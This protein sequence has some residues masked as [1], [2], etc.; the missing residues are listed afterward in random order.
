[1]GSD[2]PPGAV[3]QQ[4]R[5]DLEQWAVGFVDGEG[6][7][8]I[9][10]VRN[11]VCRLGWQ[12][13]HE[14]SVTQAAP[15]RPAL[16]LLIGVFGCG[17]IIGNNRHDDHRGQLLRF[18]VKR[19]SD[20]VSLVVPFFEE[21]PLRT[22]KRSD[23]ERFVQVLHLMQ[24]GAHLTEAGLHDIAAITQQMN[25]KQRSRYLESSEAIRQPP[26]SDNEVK[27]WSEPHGDMRGIS[28]EIPCRVSSDLHEW[29]NDLAT[30]S[31]RD[32]AKLHDE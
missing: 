19:R 16:E 8:S 21:R 25:R 18:S 14:F 6:C 28:S 32:P 3:N 15:S 11:R 27:R 17:T 4:E 29:R 30:V 26:R 7:F 2:N 24:G 12:V 22:A 13:Q 23:F 1:V 10:V 31:T 5:P 20:L 9:S